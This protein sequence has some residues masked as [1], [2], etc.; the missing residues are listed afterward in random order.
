MELLVKQC[1]ELSVYIFYSPA[2]LPIEPDSASESIVFG[3]VLYCK[4]CR[5]TMSL[6][7]YGFRQL[8]NII[9]Q[10]TELQYSVFTKS[11]FTLDN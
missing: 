2:A 3:T 10:S 8:R 9:A 4:S 6:G 1:V 7:R 5:D 11:L